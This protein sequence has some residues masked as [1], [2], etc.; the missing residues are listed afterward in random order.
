L[1]DRKWLF[2][3]FSFAPLCLLSLIRPVWQLTVSERACQSHIEVFTTTNSL[4]PGVIISAVF[5]SL[6][7]LRDMNWTTSLHDKAGRGITWGECIETIEMPESSNF[8]RN[9][10]VFFK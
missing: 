8:V 7:C 10:V 4:L 5:I 1:C 3:S 9:S 2:D 6:F